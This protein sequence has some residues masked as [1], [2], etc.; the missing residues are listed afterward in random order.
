MN[1]VFGIHVIFHRNNFLWNTYWILGF[2]FKFGMS[3]NIF[4]CKNF[5]SCR[6]H[7]V[8]MIASLI[9]TE[10]V[11]YRYFLSTK[12]LESQELH[13]RKDRRLNNQ[14]R[15]KYFFFTKF[16]KSQ[17][18]HSRN[19]RKIYKWNW[20]FF[21]YKNFWSR[22]NRT[23]AEITGSIINIEWN[24]FLSTKF[25]ESQ[26]SHSRNECKIYKWNIFFL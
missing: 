13:S 18:S 25:L 11:K 9:S 20:N 26:E 23:V 4:L 16:L 17:E 8:A 1:V 10:I 22:R 14:Y 2:M 12:Y 3:W 15:M 6:N 21:F 19:D 7:T 5:W 24:I